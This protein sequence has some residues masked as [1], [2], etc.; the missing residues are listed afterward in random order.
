MVLIAKATNS[1]SGFAVSLELATLGEGDACIFERKMN[2]LARNLA[3]S[4][5]MKT[6]C[7]TGHLAGGYNDFF[8]AQLGTA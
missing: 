2:L 7:I 4:R 6:S 1:V 8:H 3:F 5:N